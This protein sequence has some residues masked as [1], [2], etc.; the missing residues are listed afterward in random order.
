MTD[1][2]METKTEADTLILTVDAIMTVYVISYTPTGRVNAG[3][4]ISLD[5]VTMLEPSWTAVEQFRSHSFT[6]HCLMIFTAELQF[7]SRYEPI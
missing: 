3:K 2:R 5:V 1:L 6:A 4:Y 7:N